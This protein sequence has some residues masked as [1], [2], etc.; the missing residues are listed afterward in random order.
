MVGLIDQHSRNDCCRNGCPV[1]PTHSWQFSPQEIA[2]TTAT[3]SLLNVRLWYHTADPTPLPVILEYDL[4]LRPKGIVWFQ[5][6]RGRSR[7]QDG[8]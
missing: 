7:L 3:N 8:T 4:V 5:T 1:L 6:Q 2:R